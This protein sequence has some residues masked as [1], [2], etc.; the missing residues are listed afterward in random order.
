MQHAVEDAS[1]PGD[2]WAMVQTRITARRR[3]RAATV[4]GT[5]TLAVS[6]V[7]AV[8]LAGGLTGLSGT[9]ARLIGPAGY[10][11]SNATTTLTPS[12][13]AFDYFSEAETFEDLLA[14]GPDE[15][16]L[17][18]LDEAENL[19]IRD[20]IR[21]AGAG[22]TW[23]DPQA[24]DARAEERLVRQRALQR[25][26]DAFGD[27]AHAAEHGY[28]IDMEEWT[29][30]VVNDAAGDGP[31]DLGVSGVNPNPDRASELLAGSPDAYIEIDLGQGGVLGVPGAG[32]QFEAQSELWGD[33][34]QVTRSR[35]RVAN[36]ISPENLR[37]F[38]S[39]YDPQLPAADV[40]WSSC[41]AERGWRGLENQTEGFSLVWEEYWGAGRDDAATIERQVAVADAECV[42]E[43]GYAEVLEAAEARLVDHLT[44]DPDVI[45]YGALIEDAL[46]RA[47]T[48]VQEEAER[49]GAERVQPSP[50]TGAIGDAST[51]L[52]PLEGADLSVVSPA[53]AAEVEDGTITAQEYSAAFERY[54]DCMS[55]AGFELQDPLLIDG[56]QSSP[57]PPAAVETG[58]EEECQE[59]EYRYT[60]TLWQLAPAVV[61]QSST[62]QLFRDCLLARGVEPQ[63]TRAE[64]DEQ[65][66]QEGIDFVEC[67]S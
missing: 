30:V 40:G 7:L 37:Y 39:V 45:A 41:M 17:G 6:G 52:D 22:Y 13:D 65:L 43:T 9:P 28:G 51:T 57:I 32:C 1:L 61:D 31:S 50:P 15:A 58:V 5:S 62:T 35:D 47:R 33:Y 66:R 4:A 14:A 56:V 44:S 63:D 19:L 48:V 29:R 42:L 16:T 55:A 46:P 38:A 64:V 53:Q 60:D 25:Q 67:L 8:V 59:Q 20:C 27:P 2:P 24:V 11:D 34:V 21:A 12:D 18:L 49:V 54:R 3:R 36:S 10:P 26:A 23:S